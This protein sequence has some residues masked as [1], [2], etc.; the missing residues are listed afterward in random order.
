MLLA[1]VSSY[2]IAQAVAPSDPNADYGV[3]QGYIPD[4]PDRC[5][6]LYETGGFPNIALSTG[7]VDRPT[8]QVRVRG[9]SWSVN[10]TGYTSARAKIETIRSTLEG[11]MNKSIGSPLWA[12]VHIKS[13]HPPISMGRDPNDRPTVVMNFQAL[14]SRTS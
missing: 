9:P 4:K 5:I 6:A 7:T 12:Y 11:V 2:L 8:F 14:R 3:T 10:P 13:L 1:E